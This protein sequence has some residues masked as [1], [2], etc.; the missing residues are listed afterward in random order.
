MLCMTVKHCTG[1]S[2]HVTFR[3]EMIFFFL[4]LSLKQKRWNY[5][6]DYTNQCD[7][8]SA[9][10]CLL[11][12]IPIMLNVEGCLHWQAGALAVLNSW[13]GFLLYLQR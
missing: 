8:F 2:G 1:Y 5:L 12:I 7:W 10:M 9:I 6:K 13:V 3:G 4:P 11:F